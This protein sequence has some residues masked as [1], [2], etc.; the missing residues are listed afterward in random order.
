MRLTL[1]K[2]AEPATIGADIGIVDVAVHDVADNV[3]ARCPP[4]LIG[5]GNDAA[6]TGVTRREHPYDLRRIRA[7]AGLNALD[8]ALDRR[9]D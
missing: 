4:K 6:V 3:A 5:R 9:I 7:V 8:D 1:G 2:G